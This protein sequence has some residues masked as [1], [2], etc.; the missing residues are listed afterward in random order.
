MW[1]DERNADWIVKLC[2]V[3]GEEKSLDFRSSFVFFLYLSRKENA[4]IHSFDLWVCGVRVLSRY[5]IFVEISV[6]LE[7]F[8]TSITKPCYYGK[9]VF[10]LLTSVTLN[11]GIKIIQTTSYTDRGGGGGGVVCADSLLMLCWKRFLW[12]AFWVG[13]S[14]P[15]HWAGLWILCWGGCC[16]Y[17]RCKS[18]RWCYRFRTQM[19]NRETAQS[20]EMPVAW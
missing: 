1:Y 5:W 10:A 16:I 18:G 8:T 3:L 15:Q 17:V 9:A 20:D 12:S 7:G 6:S 2:L 19:L 13:S 14:I 4:E 11:R